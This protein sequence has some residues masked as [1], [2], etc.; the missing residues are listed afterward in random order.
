MRGRKLWPLRFDTPSP[1]TRQSDSR[2]PRQEARCGRASDGADRAFGVVAMPMQQ[3]PWP[4]KDPGK[5]RTTCL[6][7]YAGA[8]GVRNTGQEWFALRVNT[9][10]QGDTVF[11]GRESSRAGAAEPGHVR[12]RHRIRKG[13]PGM[14][15][16]A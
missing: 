14:S 10:T 16:S 12:R 2:E 1:N 3:I 6:R 8:R 7:H 15:D 11:G 4:G 5:A 13:S 9:D